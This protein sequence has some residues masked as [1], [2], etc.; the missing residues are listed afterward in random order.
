[1]TAKIN[2]LDC[3]V[4]FVAVA[5][6]GSFTSAAR[7]L[8]VSV[9]H[10]SRQVAALEARL[11]AQLFARTTRK[12]HL[13]DAGRR[14]FEACRPLVQELLG[15]QENAFDAQ[16]AIA[17]DIKISLAGKFA[18]QHLVPLLTRFAVLHPGVRL[19]LDVSA[20]NVDLVGEGFHLAVRMGPLE[21]SN[22]LLATRLVDIPMVLLATQQVLD[23]LPAMTSPSDI[24]PA[25]CLRLAGRSWEFIF[26][27][28]R[29]KIVPEGRISSNSGAV[30]LQA[31]AAGLGIVNVPAYYATNAYE[32]HGLIRLFPEWVS[33]ERSTFYLVFPAARHMPLRIR[34]LIDY[35]REQTSAISLPSR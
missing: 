6:S 12:M 33:A 14:L 30:L 29:V 21:S 11:N 5:E 7:Q 13:T 27:S 20:R 8:S 23:T 10:V 16:E 15:A 3:L 24:P 4:E 28:Q 1:M 22:A 34:R 19:D 2:S 9:S 26:G 35:L 17:G 25:M 31:G 32:E 18:E